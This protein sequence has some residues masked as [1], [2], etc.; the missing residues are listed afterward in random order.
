MDLSSV[1]RNTFDFLSCIGLVAVTVGL[2]L[3]PAT[4]VESAREGVELS[5]NVLLPSLFPFFVIS[6]L[7]V[8]LGLADRLG[9]LA[10][11]IMGPLFNVNGSCA[12]ALVLGL[13]GGYP[14]GAKTVIGLYKSGKCT[15]AEAER[16]LAFSNN[17]GPAFIL[18]VVG[19]GIFSSGAVGLA[20]YLIHIVSSL[21]VGLIFRGY[22][23]SAPY[24]R[25]RREARQEH[26]AL[27]A[28]F[29][30]S[31]SSSFTSTL[32]I[33]GFVIFFTV[34]IRL[35]LLSGVMETLAGVLGGVFNFAGLDEEWALRLL[36]GL[37]ELTSGVWSLRGAQGLTASA[38]MAAFM[39]GWAGLSVHCQVLSFIGE[40]GLGVRS[41]IMGKLL[42]GL[43]SAGLAGVVFSLVPMDAPV[44]AI[45][46][47]RLS[48][49]TELG[50]GSAL[51]A[52]AALSAAI[53][54]FFLAAAIIS[55]KIC[56]KTGRKGL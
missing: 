6:S 23:P 20:L 43:I 7:T 52:S 45:L 40:T 1:R 36:T 8:E 16:M 56:G 53:F 5:F 32:G 26:A 33:C 38:A 4:M 12:S 28:A 44:A 11:P 55:T 42:H 41:Y 24:V 34:L 30:R 22:G 14:V 51:A 29:V 17:S 35:L 15:K 50:F 46:A 48:G 9:R 54:V 13:I 49:I 31:V 47:E 27:P 19:A 3:N 21:V 37:V 2:I 39:L 25:A 10:S 18:G